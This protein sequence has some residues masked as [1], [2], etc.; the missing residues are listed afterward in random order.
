M[1][2]AYQLGRLSASP[3]TF[4]K[5]ATIH[6]LPSVIRSKA[7][8]VLEGGAP[9]GPTAGEQE[10]ARLARQAERAADPR[11]YAMRVDEEARRLAQSGQ[12]PGAREG[13]RAMGA[14][15]TPPPGPPMGPTSGELLEGAAKERGGALTR[16]ARAVEEGAGKAVEKGKELAS[17]AAE[18]GKE[19]AST[20]KEKATQAGGY[21]KDKAKGFGGAIAGASEAAGGYLGGKT[22]AGKHARAIA[23]LLALLTAGG[24]A[25]YMATRGGGEKA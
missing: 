13:V 18:K 25:G 5:V 15:R 17:S 11:Q 12:G 4:T 3:E 14:A 23:A 2:T 20:A 8:A 6:G 10:A 16:G 1:L 19:L 7:A 24:T 9:Y 22:P 21:I